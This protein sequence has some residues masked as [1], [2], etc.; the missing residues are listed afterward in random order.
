MKVKG[1]VLST[2]DLKIIGIILMVVDHIHQMFLPFGAPGWLDWFGRPVATLFFFA[3]AV[4]FSHTHS[5]KQYM[6]R[7]YISMV[8]MSLAMLG[9]ES[10]VN[11]DQVVLINNIF[12]DL[13]VGAIFMYGVDQCKEGWQK[14]KAGRILSGVILFLLPFLCSLLLLAVLNHPETPRFVLPLLMSITPGILLAENTLMVLLIPL[15]YIFKDNRRIQC[16]LLP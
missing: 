9:L 12:R 5:K 1:K 2:F 6:I 15:F 16:L 11:Y 4:G 10:I 14:H 3:S 8:F 7:L 13:F